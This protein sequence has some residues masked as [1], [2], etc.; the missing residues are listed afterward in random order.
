MVLYRVLGDNIY[1]Y[2]PKI[3]CFNILT[4]KIFAWNKPYVSNCYNVSSY[5]TIAHTDMKQALYIINGVA[6]LANDC[7]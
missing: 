2:L 4:C 6:V 7:I 5:R 3:V 1:V